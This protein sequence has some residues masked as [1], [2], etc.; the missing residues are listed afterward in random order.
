MIVPEVVVARHRHRLLH[1][2]VAARLR[3][4]LRLQPETVIVSVPFHLPR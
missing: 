3:H 1:T 4:A 2:N